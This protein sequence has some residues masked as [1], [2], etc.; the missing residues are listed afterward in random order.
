VTVASA[1]LG[2]RGIKK[3]LTIIYRLKKY[4]D[5][6]I[7]RYFATSS[8]VDNFC[9]NPTMRIICSALTNFL[10]AIY[11]NDIICKLS[12]SVRGCHVAGIY[13]GVV[14][15]ADDLLPI[16]S[17]R[18]DLR[19]MT[20]ICEDEMKWLDMHFNSKKIKFQKIWEA[21]YT[22]KNTVWILSMA[23]L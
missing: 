23:S 14:M 5:T 20:K 7:S 15:Y 11:L 2:I 8:I 17:T 21:V 3:Y 10:F 19:R 9:K 13:D 6:G 22:I 16:S 12:V 18:S 1:G 4:R